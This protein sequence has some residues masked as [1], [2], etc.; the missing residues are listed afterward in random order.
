MKISRTAGSIAAVAT[1]L[2]AMPAQAGQAELSAEKLRKLDIMLMVSALRCRH[3]QDDFQADYNRFAQRHLPVMSAAHRTLSAQYAGRY[4]TSGG[5]RALDKLSVS[6]ANRYG[7]GH[8]WM[9]C[10]ELGAVTRELAARAQ[11]DGLDEAADLLLA[12]HRGSALVA[13]YDR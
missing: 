11:G 6:M 2:M 9:D 12:N 13:R 10:H 1:L 8:P 3:G 7:Q 4:G 5:K